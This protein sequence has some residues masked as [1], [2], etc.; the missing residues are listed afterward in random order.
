[1][2][3]DPWIKGTVFAVAS[4]DLAKCERNCALVGMVHLHVERGYYAS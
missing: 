1:M 3:G 4:R 2:V